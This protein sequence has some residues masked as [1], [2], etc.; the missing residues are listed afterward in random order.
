[1]QHSKAAPYSH[2]TTTLS[3]CCREV[4]FLNVCV[5]LTPHDMGL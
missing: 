3:D 2:S 5:R 1:M 4:L